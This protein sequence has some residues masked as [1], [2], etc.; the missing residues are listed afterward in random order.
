MKEKYIEFSKNKY[1]G[2]A[3][4]LILKQIDLF[5]K[6]EN[7]NTNKYTV[8]E[9]VLLKKVHFYMVFMVD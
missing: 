7:I 2:E 8:G 6:E 4:E 3:L 1:S 9:D 5:Y